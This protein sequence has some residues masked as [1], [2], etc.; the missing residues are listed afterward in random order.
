[1]AH[2]LLHV[3]PWLIFSRKKVGAVVFGFRLRDLSP[4]VH[5]K[6]FLRLPHYAIGVIL[7]GLVLGVFP[8]IIAIIIGHGMMLTF[9]MFFTAGAAADFL[10]FVKLLA[11]KKSTFVLDHPD[12]IGFFIKDW[13]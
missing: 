8:C 1:V 12:K 10:C 4:Y 3:A 6:E 7:P 11:F 9:G 13:E 5:C 2:E